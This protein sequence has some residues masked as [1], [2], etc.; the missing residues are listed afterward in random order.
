MRSRAGGRSCRD[1]IRD[2][3]EIFM[4]HQ[5]LDDGQ[6][7]LNKVDTERLSIASPRSLRR[8]PRVAFG[9]SAEFDEAFEDQ[10]VGGLAGG[11]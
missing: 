1:L 5:R 9:E 8:A 6:P 10:I 2:G 4:G 7:K 11:F 3:R